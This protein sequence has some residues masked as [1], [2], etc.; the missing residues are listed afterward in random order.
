MIIPGFIVNRIYKKGSLRREAGGYY[1]FAF[2]NTLA[3]GTAS[4]A[5]A[6]RISVRSSFGNVDLSAF[7]ELF[8]DGAPVQK[9]NAMLVIGGRE[10]PHYREEEAHTGVGGAVSFA[11]GDDIIT[12]IH[13]DL[14]DGRHEF[15]TVFQS[16]QFGEMVLNFSDYVGAASKPG[17]WK[18]IRAILSKL[19]SPAKTAETK[20]AA[21]ISATKLY[22]LKD[23][24]PNPD[25]GRLLA[26]FKRKEPDR[27]PLIE[28]MVD[29]EVKV[30]FLGHPLTSMADEVEFHLA[31]GYDHVSLFVLNITPRNIT[32][33]DSHQT[34][35]KAGLQ[36][37]AWLVETEGVISSLNDFY[38]YEWPEVDDALFVNFEEIG[39]YL[40]P[41]MKVI[42]CVA[43]V[44]ETVTQAMGLQ[45]FCIGLYDNPDLIALLFE[46]AGNLVR[47]CVERMLQYDWVGAIWI[48]DDLA[49]KSGPIISP[50]MLRK[51]CFPWYKKYAD[52]VHAAGRPILL[53]SCGNIKPL[54]D[55]IIE[56]GFDALH[57]L[58]ANCVD[59]Y[60]AKKLIGDRICLMGNL[61]MSYILTRAANEEIV[62]DVKKHI[63]ELAPGGGYCLGSSNSI[64]NYV[65]M[66]K[67]LTMNRAGLEFG[68]YPIRL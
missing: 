66:D 10:I 68:K 64:A 40:P 63:R 33:I 55:D 1:S 50:A 57:P 59:I 42:G 15:R 4:L 29:E 21:P 17:W 11:K 5:A 53:H 47:Q 26:A 54:F 7:P 36:E 27:V 2:K 24:R 18:R 62:A 9:E 35:Y 46:K 52:L 14:S 6:N 60:E 16:E 20:S 12:K 44:F 45:P 3:K 48:T 31:A 30:A 37:R 13:G 67:F 41:E 22:I 19:I 65:P 25:F 32:V 38:A 39:R 58:E 49:Y 56:T 28:L 8:V 61:D 23:K 51:Y 34:T 43:A